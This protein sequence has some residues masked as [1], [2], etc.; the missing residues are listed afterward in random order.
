[1]LDSLKTADYDRY[2]SA[3]F[4]RSSARP[5]LFALYAFNYEVAKTA[6]SVSQPIAGQI[7][8]QWWRDAIAELYEGHIRAHEVVQVLA[9]TVRA[10]D[11]P[12]E[13]FDGLIDARENDLIEA[14]FAGMEALEAYCD[15]TSG[16]L[17]RLALR[18]LGARDSFDDAAQGF[19]IAYALT[20]LLRAIPFHARAG[21][22]MLPASLVSKEEIFAGKGGAKLS[23]AMGLIAERARTHLKMVRIRRIPRRFLPALLPAVLAPL[24]LKTMMRPGFDPFRDSTE[25]PIHRRQMAMLAVMLRGRL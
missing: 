22:L 19:G 6:E 9:E 5:H 2:L 8:L 10:H 15:A 17:M 4:A 16:N 21:R 24:C 23:S 12:R 13:L 20:G 18:I 1:M 7:R 14:P 3:L 11:L 25:I